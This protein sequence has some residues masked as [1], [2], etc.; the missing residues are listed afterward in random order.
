M[1]NS[2]SSWSFRRLF[3]ITF[4]LSILV[5]QGAEQTK[6]NTAG[7]GRHAASDEGEAAIKKFKV[8]EGFKVEL[9]A[10][11]PMLVNPV[12]FAFD[13][14]GRAYVVETFRHSEGTV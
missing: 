11:E 6:E 12:C 13:E 3:P 5:A 7:P 14:K 4:L 8:N 1:F 2:K 10:A 9:F